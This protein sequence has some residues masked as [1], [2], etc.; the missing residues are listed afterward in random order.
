MFGAAGTG[1]SRISSPFVKGSV[2]EEL[3]RL[4]GNQGHLYPLVLS[5]RRLEQHPSVLA[6]RQV[7][8]V[9]RLEAQHLPAPHRLGVP[10]GVF[11]LPKVIGVENLSLLDAPAHETMVV[12]EQLNVTRR[13]DLYPHLLIMGRAADLFLPVDDLHLTIAGAG[14]N[15]S[16]CLILVAE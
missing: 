3:L 14:E 8:R 10:A 6:N 5:V 13:P 16:G 2:V 9:L 15:V 7:V 1:D 4:L 11:V 12:D